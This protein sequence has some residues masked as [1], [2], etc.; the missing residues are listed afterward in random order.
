MAL[1]ARGAHDRV[2]W[3]RVLTDLQYAEWPHSRVSAELG[4]P[5]ATIRGWKAGS[6]PAYNSG[7]RLVALWA[8]EMRRDRDDVPMISPYDW[9]A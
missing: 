3:F 2:D 6:E 9:R 1:A 4:V 5:L 7:S 8:R